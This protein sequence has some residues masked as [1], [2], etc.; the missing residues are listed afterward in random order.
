MA[1]PASDSSPASGLQQASQFAGILEQSR[2]LICN[3]LD[4]AVARMLDKAK[5]AGLVKDLSNPKE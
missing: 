3:S 1:A 2:G 4:Q 5:A